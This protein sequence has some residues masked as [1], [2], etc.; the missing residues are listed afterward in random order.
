[1]QKS[2]MQVLVGSRICFLMDMLYSHKY[3]FKLCI[4]VIFNNMLQYFSVELIPRAVGSGLCYLKE[5]M[6]LLFM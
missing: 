3:P 1:M 4:C 2:N 5:N 6:K